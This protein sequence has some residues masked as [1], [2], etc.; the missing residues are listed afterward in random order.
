VI[1]L[2]AAACSGAAHSVTTDPAS[3]IASPRQ[4]VGTSR[5]PT[6]V[7]APPTTAAP[8]GNDALSAIAATRPRVDGTN[9]YSA[10][11]ANMLSPAV[12]DAKSYVYVPSAKAAGSGVVDVIDQS[13]MTVVDSFK[14]GQLAQ[15]VVPSWDLKTLYVT[16]S[17]AN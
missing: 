14:A 1:V 10:A 4:S 16:A 17:A 11:G 5:D 13:T 9:V 7:D 2:V 12:A 15:H 3:I 8:A 6:T